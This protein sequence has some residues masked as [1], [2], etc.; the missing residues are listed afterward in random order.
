MALKGTTVI[1]LTN[2]KT[3]EKER[4]V[5]HNL[6]TKALEYLYQPIPNLKM[7][8]QGITT[9]YLDYNAHGYEPPYMSK[10]GG[11]VL[12]DKNISESN[13]II[14]QPHGLK[15]VGCACYGQVNTT[16][17]P[18]RGSYNAAE[19]Y[20]TNSSTERSMKFVFDFTT[21]QANGTINCVSLTDRRSGW[22]GFGGNENFNDSNSSYF[23]SYWGNI[24]STP[25]A[26]YRSS[27]GRVFA[28]DPNGD[29]F[30][31][32][33]SVTTGSVVIAKCRAN[34]C[35]RSMF[36]NV[37]TAHPVIETIT[38]NLPTTMSTA[39]SW[40]FTYDIDHNTLYVVVSSSSS[41][42]TNSTFYVIAI[43]MGT[44]EATVYTRS[45]NTGN[46]LFCDMHYMT[47]YDGYLYHAYYD[48]SF[49]DVI[50]LSDGAYTKINVP[51]AYVSN[52]NYFMS[53]INGMIYLRLRKT[54][55]NSTYYS[56]AFIDPSDKTIHITGAD[57]RPE[58][59]SAESNT[60]SLLIPI[61]GH[62]LTYYAQKYRN[63]RYGNYF[64]WGNLWF[65]PNYLATINNLAR[66]IEKTSDKTMKITYTIQEM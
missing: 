12:W 16:T 29:A 8:V 14:T 22:N 49:V 24:L 23:G 32:I 44:Y 18:K 1:E 59:L 65:N 3:G 61:K 62:P 35:Q 52:S 46:T 51:S 7:A 5:E 47:C 54:V 53:L 9:M 48:R 25:Y 42:S 21:N 64:H 28:I 17:S 15:M 6:I 36:A 4:Y 31:E 34:L 57:N 33:T 66:P 43:D 19:S 37:Y 20:F 30:Y 10:L 40:T 50:H 45:N 13:E 41:I 39:A 63:D 26:L 27:Q 55:D 38:V 2:V 60:T 58:C 56:V 11:I